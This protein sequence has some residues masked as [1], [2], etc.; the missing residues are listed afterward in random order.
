MYRSIAEF[1][2]AMNTLFQGRH[3]R[4]ETSIAVKVSRRTHKVEIHLPIEE[5]DLALFNTDLLQF[6][7]GN[8]GNDF[9]VMLRGKGLS[10]PVFAYDIVRI[11]SPIIYTD[12]MEYIIV[13]DKKI[14]LLRCFSFFPS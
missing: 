1:L 9:G 14:S 13:G 11:H 12:L 7:G 10:K 8:V 2:E 6:Y 3:N 4:T 5:S